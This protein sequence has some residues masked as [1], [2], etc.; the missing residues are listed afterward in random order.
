MRDSERVQVVQ[1]SC[2]LVGQFASP[3]F[4]HS[5]R[6]FFEVIEKIAATHVLHNDVDVVLVF[7]DIEQPDDMWMLTHLK[8]LNLSSL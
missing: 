3:V 1:R 7:E 4:S 2:N 5:E 8:N 6:S